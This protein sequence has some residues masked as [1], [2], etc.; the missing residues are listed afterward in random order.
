MILFD[1]INYRSNSRTADA[2][3]VMKKRCSYLKKI[4][5]S[6]E[7]THDLKGSNLRRRCEPCFKKVELRDADIG[8]QN[9]PTLFKDTPKTKQISTNDALDLKGSNPR[10]RC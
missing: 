5:T 4:P 7:D 1:I 10:H 8:R 3:I 9:I 6:S 2:D